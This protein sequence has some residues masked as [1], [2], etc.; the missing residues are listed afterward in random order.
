MIGHI[1]LH[2]KIINN[3]I[4]QHSEKVHLFLHLLL[5]ANYKDTENLKRGQLLTGRNKLFGEIGINPNNIKRY[6]EQ[7]S[8][9]TNDQLIVL[10][11]TSQHSLITIVKYD[12]YQLFEKSRPTN[13]Q[14]TDQKSTTNRKNK[15]DNKIINNSNSLQPAVANE[16]NQIFEIFYETVNPA[17]QYQNKTQ[18][19]AATELIKKIGLEKAINAAKYAVSI[20]GQKYSPTITNPYQLLNK[21]GELQSYYLKNHKINVGKI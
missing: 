12:D 17:I 15:E 5:K 9:P 6:L 19:T 18:R 10:E 21:Y 4:W 3:P 7:F 20:Q 11:S 2:R 14:P 16:E 8:R 1:K 13:D